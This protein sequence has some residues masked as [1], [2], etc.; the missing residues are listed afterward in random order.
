MFLK[1]RM[2]IVLFSWVGVLPSQFFDDSNEDEFEPG[3]SK[4]S[5]LS[6]E[7]RIWARDVESEASELKMS[8][9]S[10]KCRI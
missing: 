8:N 5:E 2:L 6:S 3:M 4:I 7:R 9:L 10:S 1:A